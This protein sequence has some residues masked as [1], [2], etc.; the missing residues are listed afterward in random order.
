MN[1]SLLQI[2]IKQRLNKL[3]SFDYDNIE[4]WQIQEA[5][6]KAQIEWVR[7]QMYGINTRK[8]GEE[9]SSGLVDD[10]QRLLKH[11]SLNMLDRGIYYKSVSLPT[12]YLHYVR[13][14]V[15]AKK[16]CC[17]P[18]RM[19]IYEVEE[20]NIS[21]ILGNKDKQ[22]SFE[23]GETVATLINNDLR[24]YTN[25]QFDITEC[26]LIYYR[27]PREVE[28]NGCTNP[29]TGLVFTADQTCEFNDDIAEILVDSAASILAGDIESLTQYQREQ[30]N[31]QLNS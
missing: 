25:D 19:T 16:E 2:K 23:W 27:K 21:L 31:V 3:A 24:V 22:P 4:C 12:D 20:A 17:P 26:H 13:T 6:N 11:Q 30:Q 8:Q 18:R 29:S 7:R 5:F 9:I 15:F 10:L 28:F 14:D 1:N